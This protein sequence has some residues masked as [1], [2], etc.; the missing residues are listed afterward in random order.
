MKTEKQKKIDKILKEK[1]VVYPKPII[2]KFKTVGKVSK[3]K[4]TRGTIYYERKDVL[5]IIRILKNNRVI[6]RKF[7]KLRKVRVSFYGGK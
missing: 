5:K 1:S 3:I 4:A 7:P 6:F 2:I